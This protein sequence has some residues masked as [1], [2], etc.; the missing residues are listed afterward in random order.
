M[1]Q[2]RHAALV[3]SQPDASIDARLRELAQV[4]FADP[5]TALSRLEQLGRSAELRGAL[6]QALPIL[7]TAL[8]DAA[9][10]DHTLVNFERFVHAAADPQALLE[11]LAREPR[12]VEV[13]LKLFVGS[14]FLAE[15]LISNPA[16]LE[17]VAQH[18][19]LGEVKSREQFHAEA[20]AALQQHADEEGQMDALR[21]FQRWELLRIGGCDSF[22]LANLKTVTV[23]LSLLADSLV[24][25]S[26][27]M[28]AE[29]T[30]VAAEGFAVLAMGKLGGEEL[31]YSS[32]IDLVFLCAGESADYWPLGQRVIRYLVQP[33]A[34]GFLYR[35]DMRL[36]PWG[37]S[38]PLVASVASH[39]DY[40][41][42]NAML[43]EKQALL[44]ARV[45]AGDFRVG[46]EFLQQAQEYIFASDPQAVRD[47]IR[48]MKAKIESGLEKHGRKWGEVKSGEGSIR[49]VEFVTQYLQLI[50]GGSR[51][52]VRS[53]N[54]LEALVRLADMDLLPADEY[55]ILTDGYKFLRRVEHS[56][57]LLHYKQAHNLPTDPQELRYLARRLD[58]GSDAQFLTH[59]ERH[60]AA[61]RAIYLR[62]FGLQS[63]AAAGTQHVPEDTLRRHLARLDHSY[64]MT[65]SEDEIARHA[66]LAQRLSPEHLV[67][68]DARP[69]EGSRW[70]VTIVAYDY[71][72]ELSAICG[73]FFVHD[74]NLLDGQVFTYR[75]ADVGEVSNLPGPSGAPAPAAARYR[76]G[77]RRPP[78]KDRAA[79]ERQKKIVDVFT[80]EP[81][82][83]SVSLGFWLQYADELR[84]LLQRLQAGEQRAAQGEL[85]KRVAARLRAADEGRAVLQPVEVEI[86]NEASE[87]FTVLS[88]RALDT[89]GFLYEFTNALA[90]NGIQIARVA[91]RSR[92]NYAYDT[93]YVTD[94]HGAKITG[95]QRQRELRAATVLTKH[96]THLLPRSPNPEAALL[97]FRE[98]IAQLFTQPHWPDDLASL[99]RTEVLDAL[100]QLLGVSDFLWGD[101]LR[102]Q[103]ANL[104]PVVTDVAALSRPRSRS[105]LEELLEAELRAAP[106]Y[107]GRLTALNAFKDR[108]MFRVDMRHILR[109]IPEFGEFSAELS[110]VAELVVQTACRLCEEQLQARHGRPLA[111]DG[112]APCPYSVLALGK[113]GGRELGFAS[114][115]ELMFVYAGAGQTSGPE[116]ITA[117]EYYLK[118]VETVTQA[119]RTKREGI[120]E[121][122]LRLRPYG[123]AGS[124][125]V[126]LDAFENYFGPDGA[127]WPYERQALVKLRPI[128]G[129]GAFGW[130]VVELRDGLLYTG[131]PFDVAAMR[132]MRERQLQQLVTPGTINAKFSPGG[133]V[134]VEYLVQALQI[135]HGHRDPCLRTTNT[136]EAMI[137]LQETGILAS[138]DCDQLLSA[139]IFLRRLIDALRVVRGDAKD[140][141]VPAPQSED[142]AFLAR[143][144]G[145][146]EE[147]ESL[148]RDLTQHMQ[149]VQALGRLLEETV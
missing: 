138:A 39:L 124:L 94:V 106:D 113:C 24:Q 60:C 75:P 107:E 58:F 125:A 84:D 92:G 77:R 147:V 72:G 31:N 47:S 66:A 51:R 10:P 83:G 130:R 82:A 105:D 126:S 71:L 120:F 136:A 86:D 74:F 104:F 69:L 93:L 148:R 123:R 46:R 118:L 21:R 128:G 145:Y 79:A 67:E 88:L 34:V 99:E 134:D 81:S 7:L 141:T 59:Y 95:E 8:S 100:A 91:F 35:V 29:R 36:R 142:F 43:W 116:V 63:P 55:R 80:V 78:D 25:C 45:I 144:L 135:S 12:A 132:G 42:N 97:H 127:A 117:T 57:Q 1:S 146:N 89:P 61:I 102:M 26:L 19:K 33:T 38:G 98:F 41:R 9:N 96:F 137:A 111:P 149:H 76:Q 139:Y 73:L 140:L 109:H 37:Q 133:L 110:D 65:F 62:H 64:T 16:Y 87:Q 22:G 15:I 68:V 112:V 11:Y 85:A 70:Q 115:I 119:I 90:L 53:F 143:R 27:D 23:Q 44:K 48:D 14:Q 32:D 129:D 49:D 121:I 122:D 108:E 131:R 101:F 103:H 56:L 30:G 6:A 114:D 28:A 50:H 54:T 17:R 18:R 40:L 3:L 5:R 13:L 20:L 4:G 2:F 52:E